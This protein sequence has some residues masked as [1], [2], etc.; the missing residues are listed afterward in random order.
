[1]LQL[2]PQRYDADKNEVVGGVTKKKL[3]DLLYLWYIAKEVIIRLDN[4]EE[5]MALYMQDEDKASDFW[6]E[7]VSY[8]TYPGEYEADDLSK[9][10]D[11]DDPEIAAAVRKAD[12]EFRDK[13]HAETVENRQHFLTRMNNV[14]VANGDDDLRV[15]ECLTGS[16]DEFIAFIT[17]ADTIHTLE[18]C[19]ANDE[20]EIVFS[21]S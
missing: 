2:D 3:G 7:Q 15:L 5:L 17:L 6:Y 12:L 21:V 8:L 18:Q 13:K 19:G 4:I 9:Y 10:N 11:I 16:V 20:T 14:C 1:M